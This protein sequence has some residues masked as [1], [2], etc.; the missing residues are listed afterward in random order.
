MSKP[1]S[2]VST[3]ELNPIPDV[4]N[5][6]DTRRI[7]INKV[8]IKDI[9]HP[10]RVRD[11][12]AGEQHTIATFNMYV[13]LPHNFKGTHMSRFV[14]IINGREREISV[15][16]FGEMLAAMTARLE[17]GTGHIEMSFPYF[18]NKTAPVS[19]VNSLLDY[20]VTLIGELR[21]G[22]ATTTVKVLVPVTSLC[23]CS[24]EISRY[25]AHNQRSHVTVTARLR[26]FVWV[27][28]IIDL[29]EAEASCQLYGLLKRPDEK[30]V[31]EHAYENPKFVED[32][33]RDIAARLNRDERIGAY[34][35]ESENFESIHNH[36]AYAL[37]ECD[38][39]AA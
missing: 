13:N 14:E 27:E 2:A 18:V 3:P 10:I 34:T 19:G 26:R 9:R 22:V 6:A 32:M 24:K 16:S 7:P 15:A 28:E 12:S 31:T 8:G 37:I 30:Y 1:T 38:K 21:D 25:G 23:P 35:V 11:R 5:S 20:A 33:V 17:A 29:V 4:Q 36:S 39:D